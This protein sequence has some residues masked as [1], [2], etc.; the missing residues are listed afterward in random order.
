MELQ[1]M[2]DIT[3]AYTRQFGGD[4]GRSGERAGKSKSDW[5][6]HRL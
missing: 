5:R 4:T 6:A 1:S 3:S 2:S